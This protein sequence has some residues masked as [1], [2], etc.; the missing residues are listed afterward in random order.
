MRQL[1]SLERAIGGPIADNA[2]RKV[3]GLEKVEGVEIVYFSADGTKSFSRQF[4][5]LA[6]AV[7]PGYPT[8]RLLKNSALDAV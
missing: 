7:E 8:N 6:Q 4:N 1:T 5:R 2:N 3:P